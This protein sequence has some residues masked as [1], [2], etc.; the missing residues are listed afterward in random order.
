MARIR[1]KSHHPLPPGSP[2]PAPPPPPTGTAELK[3]ATPGYGT[4]AVVT[5]VAV[6]GLAAWGTW[7][8][9]D[10]GIDHT[11]S[12]LTVDTDWEIRSTADVHTGL[13]ARCDFPTRRPTGIPPTSKADAAGPFRVALGFDPNAWFAPMAWHREAVLHRFG[14]STVVPRNVASG[15]QAHF[16][17]SEL[18][19][20]QVLKRQMPANGQTVTLRNFVERLRRTSRGSDV[21]FDV[22]G[23]FD[24]TAQMRDSWPDWPTFMQPAHGHPSPNQGRVRPVLSIGGNGSG[25]AFH[26]HGAAWL[27]TLKGCKVWLLFA[28]N[29]WPR[30]DAQGDPL[31]LRAL[32]PALAATLLHDPPPG[33]R[34]CTVGAGQALYV[35]QGWHHATLNLGETVAVGSQVA[36]HFDSPNPKPSTALGASFHGEQA[37]ARGEDEVAL[38]CLTRATEIE[39]LNFKMAGNLITALLSMQRFDF[40]VKVA[41][42]SATTAMQRAPPHDAVYVLSF[43]ALRFLETAS[44]KESD[45]T[46]AAANLVDMAKRLLDGAASL[47]KLSPGM[48]RLRELIR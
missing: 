20:P 10:D 4:G 22:E 31:E 11:G 30:K 25:L 26:A 35:P 8:P 19:L 38:A 36:V 17:H 43:Y 40:A 2:P 13:A 46:I 18:P 5:A 42:A 39:P 29:D 44:L 7:P 24:S 32:T 1:R 47:A 45:G 9:R 12:L 16:G 27:A 23:S 33:L 41:T 28:P 3:S 6:V 34:V 37:F 14:N 48:Q 21:V 15:V